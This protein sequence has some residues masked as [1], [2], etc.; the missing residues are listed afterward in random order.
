MALYY[1]LRLARY[2]QRQPQREAVDRSLCIL[3]LYWSLFGTVPRSPSRTMQQGHSGR[4]GYLDKDQAHS[5][6]TVW[7]PSVTD[8]YRICFINGL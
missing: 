5:G 2:G 6:E 8:P 3:L 7:F 4:G 1:C